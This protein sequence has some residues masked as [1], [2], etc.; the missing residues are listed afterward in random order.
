M[1]FDVN[2]YK[3]ENDSISLSREQKNILSAKMYQVKEDMK[4]E[5]YN[6]RKRKSAFSL[7]PIAVTLALILFATGAFIGFG[8]FGQPRNSFSIVANAEALN[9]NDN[10]I[11]QGYSDTAM[12]GFFMDNPDGSP[13]L[14]DGYYDYFAEYFVIENLNFIGTNV[15]SINLKSTKKGILFDLEPSTVGKN[16]IKKKALA[17]FSDYNTL[18]N[19]QYT[20]EE[21][22]KYADKK[23][24]VVCDG[25]TYDNSKNVDGSEQVILKNEFKSKCF[26]LLLE[27]DHSDT[28]I[29][30][31]V[32]EINTLKRTDTRYKQLEKEIQK[33]TLNKAEI[34][35]TVTYTD[36]TTETKT[37]KL[38]YTGNK[39]LDFVI[40]N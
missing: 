34:L 21:F 10:Y 40:E 1:T 22:K 14:K 39:K 27:S 2:K 29:A 13:Y 20:L 4:N 17:D 26:T 5:K 23:Y 7:K 37:I 11:T 35:V 28:E 32:K 25:F 16:Y 6:K 33:K 30:K 12:S 38:K 8:S 15:K 9:G 18:K 36:N 24:S 3:M 31:W 19:S